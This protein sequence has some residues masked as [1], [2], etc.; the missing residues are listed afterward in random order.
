[1]FVISQQ[2]ALQYPI[3][4]E[5]I[6]A[7][8][9]WSKYAADP[10]SEWKFHLVN[11]IYAAWGTRCSTKGQFWSNANFTKM[12]SLTRRQKKKMNRINK[13]IETST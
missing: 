9:G 1:M 12:F 3:I 5:I 7:C 6:M 8:I 4:H 11:G 10:T 2:L 13:A